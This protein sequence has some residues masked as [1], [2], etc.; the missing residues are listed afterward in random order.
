MKNTLKLSPFIILGVHRSGTT[1]MSEIL[2]KT[3]I[4]MGKNQNIHK[5][6]DFFFKLNNKILKEHNSNAYDFDEILIKLKDPDFVSR[7]A[8]ELKHEL[9]EKMDFKFFGILRLLKNKLYSKKLKWGFKDPRTVLLLPLWLKVFPEAKMLIILRNPIDVSMS[10]YYFEQRRYLKKLKKRPDL[11]FEMPLEK[12]F[13]VWKKFT[14]LLLETVEMFPNKSMLIRYESLRDMNV[15]QDVISFTESSINPKDIKN[16][17]IDKPSNYT[18][19][20]NFNQFIELVK[21]DEFVQKLYPD[22]NN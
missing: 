3:G 7:Q 15:I 12:A 4:W 19:P 20:K 10:I 17:I 14:Y 1:L 5:E 13:I 22:I 18:K 11:K 9:Q 16:M 2:S 8:E 21:S 6:A